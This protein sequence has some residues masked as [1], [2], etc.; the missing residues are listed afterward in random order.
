MPDREMSARVAS[1]PRSSL[2]VARPF[3][4]S[5]RVPPRRSTPRGRPRV[6]WMFA[7]AAAHRR[8]A[9]PGRGPDR[10]PAHRGGADRSWPRGAALGRVGGTGRTLR[11]GV[12][13]RPQRR[14]PSDLHAPVGR[15]AWPRPPPRCVLVLHDLGPQRRLQVSKAGL[16][17]PMAQIQGAPSPD[18]QRVD[19]LDNH[20]PML[21][22]DRGQRGELQHSHTTSSPK[23][24]GAAHCPGGEPIDVD[25]GTSGGAMVA[26][27][28]FGGE[29]WRWPMVPSK[30]SP[31]GNGSCLPPAR[32]QASRLRRHA[33]L[34][35]A[36]G[37]EG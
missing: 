17:H 34:A 29:T 16:P 9:S 31:K 27:P 10:S 7:S 12:R 11:G 25:V 21:F 30:S 14:H 8:S 23:R 18:Q 26:T 37:Y 22:P 5:T 6:A 15:A 1:D 19:F 35:P 36:S 20:D 4:S 33:S 28:D 3:S 24:H 2:R 32:R 13:Q